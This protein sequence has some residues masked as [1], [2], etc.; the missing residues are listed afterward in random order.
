[1]SVMATTRSGEYY[2]PEMAVYY[3]REQ[4]DLLL[5]FSGPSVCLRSITMRQDYAML[6]TTIDLSAVF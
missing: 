3:P 1:M 5:G 2:V 6:C 4:L